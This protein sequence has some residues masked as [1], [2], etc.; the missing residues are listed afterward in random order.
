MTFSKR[1]SFITVKGIALLTVG[2]FFLNVMQGSIDIPVRSILD[3][4]LHQ[5]TGNTTWD[6]IL[7]HVRLPQALTAVLAGA[8]L[9]VAG[10]LMQT[11]FRNPM[12][13]P[14]VLG[15]SAGSSMGVAFIFL[16]GGWTSSLEIASNLGFGGNW[17]LVVASS[18][19]A[20]AVM[21]VVLFV[22][23]KVRDSVTLL[24]VGIMISYLTTAIVSI[25]QY[26]SAP[27]QIKDYLLW[28]FGS[29]KGITMGQIAPMSIILFLGFGASLYLIRSLN[30]LL[31]GENYAQSLGIS[32]KKTKVLTIVCTSL[33][34]GAVTG[35][36][37]P[38]GFIGI[39]VPHIARLMF[40]TE[41]HRILLP[42]CFWLGACILSACNLL[43]NLPFSST[44]IPINVVTSLFGAPIVIGILL[45]NR[46]IE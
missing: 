23:S 18:L 34:T 15:I 25:W 7:W 3:Y 35:F 4:L 17:L 13:G 33:L 14:S 11:F 44:A 24:I 28:T 45:K 6:N 36:C 27:D 31:L 38:I 43:A 26:F 2:L 22:A 21:F 12:A 9:S 30:A 37:G 8:S 29:L 16:A 20:L 46:Q 1:C 39:A 5:S 41:N 40:K 19:G 42:A 32:V 10:L